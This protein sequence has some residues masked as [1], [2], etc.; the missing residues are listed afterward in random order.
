MRYQPLDHCGRAEL[1]HPSSPNITEGVEYLYICANQILRETHTAESI[2]IFYE[3]SKIIIK[4]DSS[5]P[6][7]LIDFTPCMVRVQK[8]S[9]I[10]GH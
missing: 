9:T 6:F 2:Q 3:L 10:K 7:D 5:F 1:K 8:Y 4:K